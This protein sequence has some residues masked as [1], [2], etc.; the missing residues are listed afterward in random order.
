[1]FNEDITLMAL[2]GLMFFISYLLHFPFDRFH[3]PSLLASL[4]AGMMLRIIPYT[5]NLGVLASSE[6]YAFLSNIGVMLLIFL[7]GVR[8]DISEFKKQTGNMI[9]IAVLNILFT[10]LIGTVIIVSYGYPIYIAALI[11]T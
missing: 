1:M 4:I 5:S 8:I 9:L 11:S 10:A 2:L 6:E 3:M 7:V